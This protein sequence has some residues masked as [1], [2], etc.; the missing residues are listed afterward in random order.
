MNFM[1]KLLF[2]C[3]LSVLAFGADEIRLDVPSLKDATGLK[4]KFEWET[5]RVSDAK[6]TTVDFSSQSLTYAITS[7]ALTYAYDYPTN[8]TWVFD[9]DN[10]IELTIS[11]NVT[12]NWFAAFGGDF[13]VGKVKTNRVLTVISAGETNKVLR[14]IGTKLIERDAPRGVVVTYDNTLQGWIQ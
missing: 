9:R 2:V 10:Q 11:T 5:N 3:L 7:S 1:K 13:E 6:S 4:V 12:T 14:V 8:V